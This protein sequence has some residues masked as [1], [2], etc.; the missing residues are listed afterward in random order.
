MKNSIE[1]VGSMLHFFYTALKFCNSKVFFFKKEKKEN[2][3]TCTIYKNNILHTECVLS[4][5]TKN[6]TK[7]EGRGS[8]L[9]RGLVWLSSVVPG[10][11]VTADG[12][13]NG[14]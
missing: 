1:N 7:V 2:Y 6:I 9:S 14:G 10:E 8:G 4:Y 12:E 3:I 13:G 5:V 11:G